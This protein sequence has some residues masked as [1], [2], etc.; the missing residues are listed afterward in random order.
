MLPVNSCFPIENH[1]LCT[2]LRIHDICSENKHADKVC[3][4]R[5]RQ[6][7][8]RWSSKSPK[9]PRRNESLW[10]IWTTKGPNLAG[11][12]YYKRGVKHSIYV[13]VDT[14]NSIYVS[15]DHMVTICHRKLLFYSV[16]YL[17]RI[18]FVEK[19]VPVIY[20]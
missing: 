8:Q 4:H 17:F 9:I 7:T 1:Y 18:T 2:V 12:D 14:S 13:S 15:K 10:R 6:H 5:L 11:T 3:G 20:L 19:P 16:I